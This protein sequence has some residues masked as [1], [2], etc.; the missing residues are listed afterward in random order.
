[1]AS[2]ST[3]PPNVSNLISGWLLWHHASTAEIESGLFGWSIS[4]REPFSESDRVG[5]RGVSTKRQMRN[6]WNVAA[7]PLTEKRSTLLL[8]QRL[9]IGF[10]LN[11]RH[12]F[13]PE[14]LIYHGTMRQITLSSEGTFSSMWA[15]VCL[16][17]WWH[18]LQLETD[19]T[20]AFYPCESVTKCPLC[21]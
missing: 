5:S 1:M 10:T 20:D 3:S 11:R 19:A 14:K 6:G 12:P 18:I 7:S 13:T 2:C 4:C 9:T 15:P 8:S 17:V 21:S 16:P